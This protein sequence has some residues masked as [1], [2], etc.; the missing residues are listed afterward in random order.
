LVSVKRTGGRN[1]T[2]KMTMRYKGGGTR[3]VCALL[4]S[5]GKNIMFQVLSML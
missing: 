1:N 5:R 4:I 2:G 3:N